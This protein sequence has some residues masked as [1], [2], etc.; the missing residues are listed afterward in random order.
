MPKR[1]PDGAGMAREP[2][3]IYLA[4]PY[5]HPSPA[6]RAARF[7]AA[8]LAAARLIAGG[9]MVFSPIAHTHPILV[10]GRLPSGW[11]YWERF[12]RRMIAASDEVAVLTLEGWE[13]ST[14]IRAEIQITSELGKPVWFLGAE[15]RRT[16]APAP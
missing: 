6:V 7:D 4:S 2:R 3:L 11:D 14:G 5:T 16:D 8:C 10:R 1:M 12:D 9:D 13:K 15:R